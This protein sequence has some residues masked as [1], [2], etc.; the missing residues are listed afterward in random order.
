RRLRGL[1]LHQRRLRGSWVTSEETE[2]L[3]LHQRRLRGLDPFSS[4]K[5]EEDILWERRS[6]PTQCKRRSHAISSGLVGRV[7]RGL[8]TK[9][10]QEGQETIRREVD[11]VIFP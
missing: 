10:K 1:G 3:V 4:S 9:R 6:C 2:G 8:E 11:R 5:E 7:S